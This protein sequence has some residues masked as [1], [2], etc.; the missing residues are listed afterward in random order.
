MK[1]LIDLNVNL[2][3]CNNHI[4]L[5]NPITKSG[6]VCFLFSNGKER[7]AHTPQKHISA[8]SVVKCLF[9]F[10]TKELNE[11]QQRKYQALVFERKSVQL[12]NNL[13]L[14]SFL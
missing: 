10:K 13:K 7:G 1:T 6:S 2:L 4:N 11:G 12:Q 5:E 3:H 8:A 9:E 14:I